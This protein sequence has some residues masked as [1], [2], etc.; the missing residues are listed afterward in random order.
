MSD[1][2]RVALEIYGRDIVIAG[3]TF[4]AAEFDGQ[5]WVSLDK[6]DRAHIRAVAD[7]REPVTIDGQDGWVLERMESWHTPGTQRREI[8]RLKFR[9]LRYVGGDA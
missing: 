3:R 9:L 7:A 4:R 1:V 8:A 2:G 5:L 6:D